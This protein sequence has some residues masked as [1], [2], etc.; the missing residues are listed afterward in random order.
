MKIIREILMKFLKTLIRNILT[1][2]LRK[3][4]G[5]ILS[6]IRIVP[7]GKYMLHWV[8]FGNT[9]ATVSTRRKSSLATL[10]LLVRGPEYAERTTHV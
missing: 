4:R 5:N 7:S 1:K 9:S 2:I 3:I 8:C 6:K 10:R